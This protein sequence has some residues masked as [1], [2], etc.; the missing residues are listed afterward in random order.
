MPCPTKLPH[1]LEVG[2]HMAQWFGPPYNA[3]HVGII[4]EINRRRTKS[5]NVSV[6][7]NV[8]TEGE[9]TSVMVADAETYGAHRLWVLLKPI[10]VSV[11][12]SDSSPLSSPSD[13]DSAD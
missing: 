8:A 11:D 7:F 12:D 4:S 3:W 1:D 9:T 2:Q 10:P 6:Q 5:E 13:R